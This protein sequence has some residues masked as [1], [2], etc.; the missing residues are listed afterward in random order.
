MLATNTTQTRFLARKSGGT[1]F[2]IQSSIL[3]MMLLA[4]VTLNVGGCKLTM[5]YCNVLG[6]SGM[7][8]LLTNV[9]Y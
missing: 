6:F 7:S 8:F 3:D 2:L 9:L 4:T 1:K 5:N